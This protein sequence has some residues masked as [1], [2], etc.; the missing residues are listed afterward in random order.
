MMSPSTAVRDRDIIHI[1]AELNST[2]AKV[3]SI[4]ETEGRIYFCNL[5]LGFFWKVTIDLAAISGYND[6][7]VIYLLGM[8]FAFPAN[9]QK[10]VYGC[11]H[12]N[13]KCC[14]RGGQRRTIR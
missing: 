2:C 3:T 7:E 5:G 9:I 14:E 8:V 10:E 4:N 13:K 1:Y 12:R 11:G 6:I